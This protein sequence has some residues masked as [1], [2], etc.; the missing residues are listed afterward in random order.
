[1]IRGGAAAMKAQA[2]EIERLRMELPRTSLK[3]KEDIP[4]LT[5][6]SLEEFVQEDRVTQWMRLCLGALKEFLDKVGGPLHRPLDHV[7]ANALI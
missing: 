3:Q 1:M 4:E 5:S 2:Q 7:G 6:G